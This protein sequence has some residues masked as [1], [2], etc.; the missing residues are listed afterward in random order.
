MYYPGADSKACTHLEESVIQ[1]SRTLATAV[2]GH[3]ETHS[4]SVE[5][6]TY[7]GVGL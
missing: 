6:T 2:T 3:K 7:L 5:I 4:H 1:A